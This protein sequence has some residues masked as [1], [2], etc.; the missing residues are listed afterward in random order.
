M[1]WGGGIIVCGDGCFFSHS[2]FMLVFRVD[3]CLG[4]CLY[5]LWV[6]AVWS[7]LKGNDG[8]LVGAR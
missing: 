3:V 2:L 1:Y 5:Q 8:M 7:M 4:W 6:V